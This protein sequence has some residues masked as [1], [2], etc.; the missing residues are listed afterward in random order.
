[1]Q[2]FRPEL[3]VYVTWHPDFE[4]G[5]AFAEFL[6]SEL[7][8]EKAEPLSRGLGIPVYLSTAPDSDS[9]PT[10]VDFD[11]AQHTV[12]VLLVDD[13]MADAGDQ[14]IKGERWEDYVQRL[15]DGVKRGLHR[16]IPVKL[17]EDA[18][19]L[20]AGLARRNFLPIDQ[21]MPMTQQKQRLLIGVVHDLCRLLSGSEAVNYESKDSITNPVRVF[22]SHAKMDG[23]DLTE[24]FKTFLQN[25]LQLD[26]FFDRNGIFYADDFGQDIEQR[27]RESAM[28]ILQTDA[29]STREWCQK[30]VLLAKL[31][32]RPVLVLQK[33]EVGETR[34]FP[35][36]GNVPTLR[37]L[38]DTA[39]TAGTPI[40]LI[41]G[42]LLL[43]VLRFLYFPLQARG[44]A[45]LFGIDLSN[46]LL[47]AHSPELINLIPRA[48]SPRT[49]VY[50]DPP[51]GR[52]EI[53][54]LQRCDSNSQLSTPMFLVSGK[55]FSPLL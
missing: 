27:A 54:L 47:L 29:Y 9:L 42:K 31:Y 49:I 25:E 36:I 43:E 8:R 1:M 40:E 6:Y 48:D 53:D 17:S 55:P 24:K 12:V 32:H 13:V 46:A 30:E 22:L 35:Y 20:H 38:A 18:F 37:Y 52:H 21:T 50:P 34:S 10:D 16:I 41:V 45:E 14:G 44:M 11:R 5:Q 39:N 4:N 28:L 2:T 33:I 7:T 23:E 15:L 51:V 26:T 3:T 19:S